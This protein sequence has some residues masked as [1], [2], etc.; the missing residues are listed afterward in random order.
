MIRSLDLVATCRLLTCFALSSAASAADAASSAD[1]CAPR[2]A[3]RYLCGMHHPEDLVQIPNTAWIHVSGM[4]G[5]L[6]GSPPGAG[7]LY[8]LNATTRHWHPIAQASLARS[9]CNGKIYGD[10]PGPDATAFVAHGLAIRKGARGRRTLY[11]VNHGGREAMAVFAID[12][13]G[14]EPKLSWTDC[15]EIKDSV[16]LNA[17]APLPGGGFIVASTFDPHDVQARG[18]MTSGQ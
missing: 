8:L 14:A 16:W 5:S 10:C 3:V 11:A 6:P 2:G 9:D 1:P 18:R 15:V 12:A 17:I 7:D 13:R 4:G